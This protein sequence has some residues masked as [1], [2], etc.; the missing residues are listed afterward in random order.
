MHGHGS[1]SWLD[2]SSRPQKNRSGP[3]SKYMAAASPD[4]GIAAVS[5]VTYLRQTMLQAKCSHVRRMM[6]GYDASRLASSYCQHASKPE[7]ETGEN[8]KQEDPRACTFGSG[9]SSSWPGTSEGYAS[10]FDRWFGQREIDLCRPCRNAQP[11]RL[12]RPHVAMLRPR[13]N[14]VAC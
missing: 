11:L 12:H 5:Y 1:C 2:Q 8:K 3:T 14:P 4:P 9:V 10:Q 6:E 13:A 7:L